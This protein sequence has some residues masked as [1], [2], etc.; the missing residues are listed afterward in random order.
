MMAA[1]SFAVLI[2]LG[3]DGESY[4]SISTNPNDNTAVIGK[5]WNLETWLLRDVKIPEKIVINNIEYTVTS[6]GKDA[7]RGCSKLLSIEIPRTV[8][9]I[10]EN[11]FSGCSGLKTIEIPNTITS[12]GGGAFSSCTGLTSI[13]I[14]S[15]VTSL[16]SG[17]FSNC[18]GLTSVDIPN[19]VTDLGG[20]VF[21]GCTGLQT[22]SLPSTITDLPSNFFNGCT[23]LTSIDKLLAKIQRIGIRAFCGCTGLR[24]VTL[25]ESVTSIGDCAFE[26]CTNLEHI[27]IP[28]SVGGIGELAFHNCIE[29]TSL[30]I[31]GHISRMGFIPFLGC[32]NLSVIY[33]QT[34]HDRFMVDHWGEFEGEI[35]VAQPTISEDLTYRVQSEG[36]VFVSVKV[37]NLFYYGDEY[38]GF[39]YRKMG[40]VNEKPQQVTATYYDGYMGALISDLSPG[41]TYEVR[42]FGFKY[43]EYD[44]LELTGGWT[45]INV[46][47][48]SYCEP[49]LY[50][51]DA[52]AVF[53]YRRLYS[54]Y[55]G[56]K[57]VVFSG[58]DE[59]IEQGFEYWE[60]T[61]KDDEELQPAT[62]GEVYKITTENSG[63]KGLSYLYAEHHEFKPMASYAARVYA[64]TEKGTFYGNVKTFT[65]EIFTGIE[66]IKQENADCGGDDETISRYNLNGEPVPPS[67]RGIQ[68]IRMKNGTTRKILVK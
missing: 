68:I 49:V 16:G 30:V 53:D 38:M 60:V 37:G 1:P 12:I 67:Y 17:V 29:L 54:C 24:T 45:Q 61:D 39:K 64:T 15:S 18:T 3:N 2:D 33:V 8:T 50:T 36:Q 66:A 52:S 42:A 47:E 59:I 32:K 27:D 46:S 5:V 40:A 19:S 44:D 26:D 14:P 9:T 62:E 22:V 11:A 41:E 48:P 7:F 20:N 35:V 55:V 51:H 43:G 4:I 65:T 31:P 10:Q 21:D 28:I 56:F 13:D 34:D 6:I 58:T 57:G 23:G 63:Y 25:P